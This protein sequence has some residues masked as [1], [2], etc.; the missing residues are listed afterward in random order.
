[1]ILTRPIVTVRAKTDI[2]MSKLA[3]ATPAT[4]SGENTIVTRGYWIFAR[5]GDVLRKMFKILLR[6]RMVHF[7]LP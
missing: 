5:K 2:T 3:M 7:A 4:S 1:M 6:N